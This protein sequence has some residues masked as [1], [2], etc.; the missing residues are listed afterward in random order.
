MNACCPSRS[1]KLFEGSNAH[2]AVA[3]LGLPPGIHLAVCSDVR[4]III[5]K[6]S[7]SMRAFVRK[8]R[9][10]CIKQDHRSCQEFSAAL[11]L[12]RHSSCLAARI[13]IST[14]TLLF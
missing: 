14:C 9:S 2:T 6:L 7:S 10:S 8:R 13:M 1:L 5:G 3:P 11:E 4:L 12:L